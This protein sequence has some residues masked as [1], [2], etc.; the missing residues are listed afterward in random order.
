MSVLTEEL[1]QV[2]LILVATTM[3]LRFLEMHTGLDLGGFC[4]H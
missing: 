4:G 2:M 3:K 1:S